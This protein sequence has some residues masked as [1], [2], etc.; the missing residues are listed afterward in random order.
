MLDVLRAL[1]DALEVEITRLE[2]VADDQRNL[3]GTSVEG[4]P[5]SNDELRHY[6]MTGDTRSLSMLVQADG[7][8]TVIP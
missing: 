8:Y 1:G 4:E 3:P 7:G 6:I 2:A 5:V